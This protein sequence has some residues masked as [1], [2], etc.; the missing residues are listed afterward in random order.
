MTNLVGAVL[1]RPDVHGPTRY[2]MLCIRL[3][4]AT[5]GPRAVRLV[6]SAASVS[7]RGWSFFLGSTRSGRRDSGLA[8][9]AIDNDSASASSTE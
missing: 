6:R 2:F 1:G 7:R 9:A 5:I 4:F 3:A 8:G